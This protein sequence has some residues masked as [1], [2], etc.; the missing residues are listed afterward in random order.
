[1][2]PQG[3]YNFGLFCYMDNRDEN[4]KIKNVPFP[5]ILGTWELLVYS[6]L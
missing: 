6:T 5:N 4:K 3:Y 1:M 2:S